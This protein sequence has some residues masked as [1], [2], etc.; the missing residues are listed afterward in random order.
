MLTTSGRARVRSDDVLLLGQIV[1]AEEEGL[2]EG[3][4]QQLVG[5]VHPRHHQGCRKSDLQD[6]HSKGQQVY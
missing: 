2:V 6:L 1:L 4:E 5:I 3:R